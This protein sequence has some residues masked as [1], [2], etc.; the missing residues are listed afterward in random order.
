MRNL[1]KILSLVLALMM[2]LSVMATAN[3]ATFVDDEDISYKEAVEVMVAAGILNGIK[4]EDG[5]FSFQPTE[6]LRRDAAA[7]IIAFVNLG[8]DIDLIEQTAT[9]FTDVPAA[10]WA[11][12]YISYCASQGIIDGN[13]DGTY[14]PGAYLT[15]YQFAKMLLGI[16]GIEGEYTGTG[17]ETRVHAAAKKAGL[18]DNLSIRMSAQLTREQACQM[19]FN[20]L[21][22]TETGAVIGY[23]YDTAAT[24]QITFSTYL[25]AFLFGQSAAGGAFD[26]TLIKEK[27]DNTGSILADS[28]GITKVTGRDEQGREYASKWVKVNADKTVTPVYA[29]TVEADRTLVLNATI[30]DPAL[31][32]EKLANYLTYNKIVKVAPLFD[33]DTKC[34]ID[35][36]PVATLDGAL[37]EGDSVELYLNAT[38]EH[39]ESA[40]VTRD[41]VSTVAGVVKADAEKNVKAST[42]LADGTVLAIET[43]EFAKGDVVLYN[44]YYSVEDDAYVVKGIV[45]AESV[46]GILT[47][48]T[49]KD[50]YTIGGNAYE[51]SIV[52]G[53]SGSLKSDLAKAMGKVM[54]YSLDKAGKIVAVNAP[55]EDK[56]GETPIIT[57]YAMVLAYDVNVVTEG[58]KWLGESTFTVKSI[59]AQVKVLLNDGTV[60]VYTLP[61]VKAAKNDANK[62]AE[63]AY[64]TMI[65][66]KPVVLVAADSKDE[67][68]AA[69]VKA[70]KALTAAIDLAAVYTYTEENGAITLTAALAAFTGAETK[71]VVA[72]GTVTGTIDAKSVALK[73]GSS[74]VIANDTTVFVLKDAKGNVVVKTGAAALEKSVIS[75]T[76]Y[77]II[78]V[79]AAKKVENNVNVAKYV[80]A[81]SDK[82]VADETPKAAED[83]VYVDGEYVI[84]VDAESK[85]VYK[86][87]VTNVAGEELT[88]T[89]DADLAAGLYEYTKDGKISKS[90]SATKAVVKVISGTTYQ[91]GN[92]FVTVNDKTVVTDLTGKGLTV[93]A[94]VLY[95]ADGNVVTNIFVVKAAE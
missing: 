95:V 17:W 54:V 85:V 35:G 25:E 41:Y 7:K 33:K 78:D 34:Y 24:K 28:F 46:T 20:A 30:D 45:K 73:V 64:Y 49:S 32:S 36:L 31:T 42:T 10:H 4:N 75:G 87:T 40:V 43:E 70:Q 23:Y 47:S 68:S 6:K 48:F 51:L 8:E 27:Q 5:T 92:A 19:A 22:Y 61:V 65:A 66:G 71:N 56:P 14:E 81:I 3:A 53:V 72:Q 38:G 21:T 9:E 11:S 13:G 60:A 26:A 93:G 82:F 62:V 29:E 69:S 50:V 15:G 39:V 77:V 18:T 74:Y 89:G 63:G 94:T 83:L 44:K 1:K 57:D 84:S 76:A 55:S 88:L 86:Y 90:A 58:G 37:N 67:S 80:L 79:T 16:L 91:L 2:V 59:D 52:N 12:G